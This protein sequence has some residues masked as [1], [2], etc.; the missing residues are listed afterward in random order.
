VNSDSLLNSSIA[1][2]CEC[3]RP[4]TLIKLSETVCGPDESLDHVIVDVR[5][6]QTIAESVTSDDACDVA[7]DF[8]V[9]EAPD[10][11]R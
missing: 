7:N 9:A 1:I 2:D 4:A 3:L 11:G 10:I 5:L 6:Q 8:L